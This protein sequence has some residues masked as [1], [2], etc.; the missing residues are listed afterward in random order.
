[1]H[2][3]RAGPRERVA[4]DGVASLSDA[5]LLAL[6]LGTGR[7]REPV[8]VLSA[9]LLEEAGGL[10]GLAKAG[11]GLLSARAGV[12][13]AKGARLAA[14]LELGRRAATHAAPVHV[15]SAVDVAEWARGRI[16][17]LDHEELWLLAL[18][19]ASR[20]R[21]ARRIAA[22]GLHGVHVA[23]R[24]P[25]RGA[26]REA[27][28][29]F[30]LVHNHPSGDPTASTEDLY[31]TDRVARAAEVVGT[32]LVDHVIVA[33]DGW[34]SLAEIGAIRRPPARRRKRRQAD[35]SG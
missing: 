15:R 19:G 7:K 25:L 34:R 29:A 9:A 16:A 22:G 33:R 31:F 35:S 30:V 28:S 23:T 18:D 3:D 11:L 24:D 13:P 32:P 26:L 21:A 12:G 2:Q 20:L 10:A 6:V 14:A 8:H 17:H 27:A 5:E 1:M 4:I